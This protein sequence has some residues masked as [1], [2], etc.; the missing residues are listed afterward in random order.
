ML[1]RF[2]L[3]NFNKWAMVCISVFIGVPGPALGH[4]VVIL[5]AVRDNTLYEEKEGGTSNGGGDFLFVGTSGTGAVRR[6]LLAFDPRGKI[7]PGALI[8]RVQIGLYS[9]NLPAAAQKISAHRMLSAWGEGDSTPPDE[10]VGGPAAAG[11]ATWKHA[12]FDSLL[13]QSGGGDF[14]TEVSAELVV[15]QEGFHIW[16]AP[17]LVADVQAWA[18]NPVNNPSWVLRGAEGRPGTVQRFSSR[19]NAVGFPPCLLIQFD[20]FVAVVEPQGWG[21]LK[22]TWKAHGSRAPHRHT[23]DPE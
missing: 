6:A 21:H 8:E 3:G 5:E 22:K 7:P 16:E 14:A 19:E 23:L 20:P 15:E 4:L 1:S 11:D 18:I 12:F 13:W 9:T 2:F 17:G 10:A